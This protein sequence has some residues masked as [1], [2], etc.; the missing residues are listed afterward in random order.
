LVSSSQTCRRGQPGKQ[1]EP[2]TW[3]LPGGKLEFGESFESCAARELEE[4]TGIRLG[5][6][7]PAY[8][9][10]VNTVFDEANHFVTIFMSVDVHP[11]T[12]AVNREPEKHSDW[13]WV[14]WSVLKGQQNEEYRPLMT[15]LQKLCDAKEFEL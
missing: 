14:P 15:P 2:N 3:A 5:T 9:F 13:E 6:S 11:D 4:E 12:K 1:L 7:V 8:V 10:A